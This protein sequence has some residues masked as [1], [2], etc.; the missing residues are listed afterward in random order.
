MTR[1]F[2]A[3]RLEKDQMIKTLTIE[4]EQMRTTYELRIDEMEIE[5]KDLTT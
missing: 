5:N 3:M 1:N 4:M 2:E